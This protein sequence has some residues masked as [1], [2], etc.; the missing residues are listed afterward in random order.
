MQ[1]YFI[2]EY[3]TPGSEN[4]TIVRRRLDFARATEDYS[5]LVAALP[6]AAYGHGAVVGSFE[7]RL[8]NEK[9]RRDVFRTRVSTD[10]DDPNGLITSQTMEI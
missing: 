1:K 8:R 7:C 9:T 2:T 5:S 6:L 10:I 4:W 3:R